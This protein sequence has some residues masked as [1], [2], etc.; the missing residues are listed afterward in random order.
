MKKS[1]ILPPQKKEKTTVT[2]VRSVFLNPHRILTHPLSVI[3]IV[4]YCGAWGGGHWGR[5]NPTKDN[6][7]PFSV[8][9]IVKYC[10]VG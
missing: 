10:G 3:R 6:G 9:K 1:E 8:I 2:K 5:Q 4:K 7:T